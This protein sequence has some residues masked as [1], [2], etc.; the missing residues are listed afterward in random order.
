M[1][2]RNG[3]NWRYLFLFEGSTGVV[4]VGDTGGIWLTRTA[5]RKENSWIETKSVS[6]SYHWRSMATT[7]KWMAGS[8]RAAWSW[9]TRIT[10]KEA[11]A[12][13]CAILVVVLDHS[14]FANKMFWLA[15]RLRQAHTEGCRK[16]IEETFGDTF[17]CKHSGKRAEEADTMWTQ[18][19]L[20]QK[21]SHSG[22]GRATK[23]WL[24]Y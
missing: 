16:T 6:V 23:C 24:Y 13:V 8:S 17:H 10:E 11:Y 7:P 2:G 9:C 1:I 18:W 4:I 14:G 19:T 3:R 12:T 22:I 20:L 5:G 21:L 15:Y